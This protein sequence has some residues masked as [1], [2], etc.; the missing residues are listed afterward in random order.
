[1]KRVLFLCTGNS[2]RSQMAHG[3]LK[4]LGGDAYEVYSA[5]IETHGVNPRAIK[6]MEEAGVDI[7]GYSSNSVDE[8][9]GMD[10]DLL[11]TVCAGAK[12]RC[13][14]YVGKVK[15]RA[16]WPFE[17][18]AAAEGTEDEIM[19]VFRRIRDEIKLRIQ[20]FLEENS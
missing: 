3:W 2:C 14:I 16:H 8:Y 5:G 15:K 18:P 1:M 6:V 19:N 12:E 20:R 9:I 11:V 4:E 10:L 17:D 13:P 7:S